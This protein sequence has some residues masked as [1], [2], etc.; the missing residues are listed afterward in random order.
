MGMFDS[1]VEIC[2]C[3]GKVEFQSK[4]GNCDMDEFDKDSVPTIIAADIN[5]ETASC[6]DCY[7]EYRVT[8]LCDRVAMSITEVYK[9]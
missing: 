1:V 4:A 8:G 6:R 5:N 9:K 2:S 3:G 7:K